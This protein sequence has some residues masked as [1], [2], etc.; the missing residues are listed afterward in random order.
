MKAIPNSL[1]IC[2]ERISGERYRLLHD[3]ATEGL[4]SLTELERIVEE[5]TIQRYNFAKSFHESAKAISIKADVDARNVISRNYY[6]MFHAARAVIFHFY[7]YDEEK[8]EEV[9]KIIGNILGDG[10]RNQL[11]KSKENRNA[12]D[13]SPFTELD[14]IDCANSSIQEVEEFLNECKTFLS[15]RGVSL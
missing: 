2:F 4:F 9:I 15:K 6:A 7:R 3:L 8:H 10:S 5:F 14:L 1:L 12:A 13:Y 11:R